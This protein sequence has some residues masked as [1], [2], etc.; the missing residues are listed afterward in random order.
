M[1]SNFLERYLLWDFRDSDLAQS[2]EELL[3]GPQVIGAKA[4]LHQS[5][6]ANL[7]LNPPTCCRSEQTEQG[8]NHKVR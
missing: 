2:L 7:L 3:F 6:S 4:K 8:W 1:R 5:S